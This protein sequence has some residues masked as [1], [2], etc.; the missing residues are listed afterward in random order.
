MLCS[1]TNMD[2]CRLTGRQRAEHV[3][4]GASM[5]SC[6]GGETRPVAF[7]G[8]WPKVRV[9]VT[10]TSWTV[11]LERQCVENLRLAASAWKPRRH[12]SGAGS[13]EVG[14]CRERFPSGS[15]IFSIWS[16]AST[17]DVGSRAMD[18]QFEHLCKFV[19]RS[20]GSIPRFMAQSWTMT[21]RVVPD[22]TME[23]LSQAENCQV[24]QALDGQAK[25]K[26]DQRPD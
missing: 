16:V 25:K 7:S 11:T 12:F 10:I 20:R 6:F 4:V 15:M 14:A 21:L 17:F 3:D 23:P 2:A 18:R 8:A 19:R 1:H 9:W 13:D 5:C 26:E 22:S 24:S